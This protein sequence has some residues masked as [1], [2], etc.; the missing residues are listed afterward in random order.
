MN[1]V[2][3]LVISAEAIMDGVSM[4][5]NP[6]IMVLDA[7]SASGTCS[8]FKKRQERLAQDLEDRRVVCQRQGDGSDCHDGRQYPKPHAYSILHAI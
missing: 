1:L 8:R 2:I 6:T 7:S 4:S 5:V 3:T